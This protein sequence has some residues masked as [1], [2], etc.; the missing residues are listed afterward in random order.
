MRAVR[1]VAWGLLLGA[2]AMGLAGEA[3]AQVEEGLYNIR[4]MRG[5]TGKRAL[6]SVPREGAFSDLWLEDDASGR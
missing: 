5:V 6:L 1:Q 4:I 3:Q 2:S